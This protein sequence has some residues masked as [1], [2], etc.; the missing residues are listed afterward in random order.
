MNIKPQKKLILIKKIALSI[1]WLFLFLFVSTVLVNR[2]VLKNAWKPFHE[3]LNY[4]NDFRL[5]KGTIP[6]KHKTN[7]KEFSLLNES[8]QKLLNTNVDVWKMGHLMAPSDKEGL[9]P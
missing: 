6:K 4:L 8:V 1:L 2:L 3:I 9:Y 7:I 5:D